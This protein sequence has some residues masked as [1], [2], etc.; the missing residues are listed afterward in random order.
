MR[1]VVTVTATLQIEVDAP[2]PAAAMGAILH[3]FDRK[4]GTDAL[5]G[6][7]FTF[8]ST[9]RECS[10]PQIMT[11]VVDQAASCEEV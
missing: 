3:T 11:C 4:R 9:E 7:R 5:Q 1:Y 8:D 6:T 10:N 2:R